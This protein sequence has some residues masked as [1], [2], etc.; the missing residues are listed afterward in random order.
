MG[1]SLGRMLGQ[2]CLKHS[3]VIQ[4]HSQKHRPG[5]LML[6]EEGACPLPPSS[7]TWLIWVGSWG[8]LQLRQ[9]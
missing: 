4:R 7:W 3:Q 6:G 1:Q 9:T 5:A 8:A 2:M